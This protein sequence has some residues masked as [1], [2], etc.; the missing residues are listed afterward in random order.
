MKLHS[1]R[2]VYASVLFPPRKGLP[3]DNCSLLLKLGGMT[4]SDD[5]MEL[6]SLILPPG[7][8]AGGLL[9]RP[10]YIKTF[11]SF[12]VISSSIG[13]SSISIDG[14]QLSD[15]VVFVNNEIN[16][17]HGVERSIDDFKVSC[18]SDQKLTI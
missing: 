1:L 8:L 11:N 6:I 16:D 3:S 9:N 5:P 17:R 4:F 10:M 12:Q 7:E 15:P 14:I 13:D 2:H 18:L